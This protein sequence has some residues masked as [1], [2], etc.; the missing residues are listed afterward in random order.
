MSARESQRVTIG[1][2]LLSRALSAGEWSQTWRNPAGLVALLVL[3]SIVSY[4]VFRLASA[5]F[6][7]PFGIA[8][9][10]MGIGY[11]TL[12][13]QSA[14]GLGVLVAAG[15]SVM[16]VAAYLT[17]QAGPRR[18]TAEAWRQFPRWRRVLEPAA[19]FIVLA[20]TLLF[21]L[22]ALA[23]RSPPLFI[24]I[25]LA[26]VF[27]APCAL[28]VFRDLPQLHAWKWPVLVLLV[29]AWGA[30]SL[31]TTAH[32]R[33][34]DA[35][36]HGEGLPPLFSVVFQWEAR[37][38]RIIWRNNNAMGSLDGSC[39][40][41]LGEGKSGPMVLA[42]DD[43]GHRRTLTITPEDGSVQIDPSKSDCRGWPSYRT[44]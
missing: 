39:V 25:E 35:R 33:A 19:R 30:L 4:A 22:A 40:L 3:L 2:R 5:I 28:W 34:I 37:P 11:P 21:A 32:S 14:L 12:L 42:V 10:D 7:E 24:L 27:A 13:A 41:Y 36:N 23:P 16:A 1:E 18:M 6:Y 8:P 20:A 43:V 26:L 31:C 29:L 15:A 38:A 9:E 17:W 44:S